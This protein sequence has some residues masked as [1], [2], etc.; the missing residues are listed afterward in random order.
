VTWPHHDS[1]S[2]RYLNGPPRGD[3]VAALEHK[4]RLLVMIGL[5]EPSEPAPA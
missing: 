4:L 3:F 5:P 1:G 2:P